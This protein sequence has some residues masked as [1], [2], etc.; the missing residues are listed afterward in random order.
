MKQIVLPDFVVVHWLDIV[1]LEYQYY[2][3]LGK[4][5]L[6][7]VQKNKNKWLNQNGH[8]ATLFSCSTLAIYSAP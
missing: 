3:S 7:S 5:L 2:S 8:G 4:V 1:L 6:V